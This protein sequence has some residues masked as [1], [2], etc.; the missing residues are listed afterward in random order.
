LVQLLEV[1]IEAPAGIEDNIHVLGATDAAIGL[2]PGD[3]R[4]R[5]G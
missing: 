5:P 2:L 3:D 4:L 1:A